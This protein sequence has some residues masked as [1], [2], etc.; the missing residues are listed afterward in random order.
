MSKRNRELGYYSLLRWI[1]YDHNSPNRR[2]K[3]RE[4]VLVYGNI[5]SHN[6]GIAYAFWTYALDLDR[7]EKVTWYPAEALMCDDHD[8]LVRDNSEIHLWCHIPLPE[9]ICGREIL[10]EI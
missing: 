10:R 9:N 4:L 5:D 6:P 1:I 8:F 7:K 3:E 2:P